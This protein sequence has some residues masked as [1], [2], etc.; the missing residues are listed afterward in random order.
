MGRS[1]FR[2]L[3]PRHVHAKLRQAIF[4]EFWSFVQVLGLMVW[5]NGL[6]TLLDLSLNLGQAECAERLNIYELVCELN[7]GTCEFER[8]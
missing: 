7:L 3:R 6:M 5:C 8:R 2:S 1:S 4:S